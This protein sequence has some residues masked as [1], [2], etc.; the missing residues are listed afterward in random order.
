MDRIAFEI[1]G[2][3]IVDA[4]LTDMF[5]SYLLISQVPL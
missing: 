5:I 3:F 1:S 4:G 2:T